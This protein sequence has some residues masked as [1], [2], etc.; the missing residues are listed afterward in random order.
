[1][2]DFKDY[3]ENL[4]ETFPVPKND[5]IEKLTDFTTSPYGTS[6]YNENS[7]GLIKGELKYV[8]IELSAIGIPFSPYK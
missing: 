7:I 5:F 8:A 3:I 4:G 2:L 6:H 1:M